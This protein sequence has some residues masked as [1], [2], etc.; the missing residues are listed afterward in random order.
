MLKSIALLGLALSGLVLA[1]GEDPSC[2]VH[3]CNTGH[4]FDLSGLSSE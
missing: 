2:R 3:D 1:N 4:T